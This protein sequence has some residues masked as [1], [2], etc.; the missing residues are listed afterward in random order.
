MSANQALSGPVRAEIAANQVRRGVG[1]R[2][3]GLPLPLGA[4]RA[5]ARRPGPAVLAHQARHALARGAHTGAPQLG[6]DLRSAVDAAAG[7]VYL[8]DLRRQLGVAPVA[9]AGRPSSPRVVSL[10]GDLERGAHLRDRPCALVEHD[11][12]ELG[13]LRL[14]AYSCLLA[15]KA[16]AFK[17]ISFSRLSRSTSRRS[18]RFSSA[19]L[20]GL[21][22][23]D[24]CAA[25]ALLTQSDMLPASTPSSRAIS[26]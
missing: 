10:P 1:L 13:P 23:G 19:T 6:E 14:R 2:R 3:G 25:S 16:L 21:S 15:K 17:S 9:R 5:S 20:K 11:E 12:S 8:G 7:G 26:A 22:S 4:P 18:L 24:A